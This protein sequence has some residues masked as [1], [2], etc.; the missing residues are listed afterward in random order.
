MVISWLAEATNVRDDALR[1]LISILL[2]YPIA[3]FYRYFVYNKQP[4]IQH[5]FITLVGIALYWFNCGSLLCFM[6]YLWITFDFRLCDLSQF[7]QYVIG[8]LDYE[9]FG[10]G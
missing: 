6:Y 8:I 5:W 10:K 1:L 4:V 3:A 7:D 2:G 9:L